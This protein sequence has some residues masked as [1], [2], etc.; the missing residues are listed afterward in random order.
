MG[1]SGA[2]HP[3]LVAV[4]VKIEGSEGDGQWGELKGPEQ[5]EVVYSVNT[6]FTGEPFLVF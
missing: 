5:G 4:S 2:H 1:W 3:W 6:S